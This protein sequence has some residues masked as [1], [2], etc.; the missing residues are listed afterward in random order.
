MAV[1]ARPAGRTPTVEIRSPACCGR[2]A[3]PSAWRQ[4][5]ARVQASAHS[6]EQVGAGLLAA[7]ACLGADLTVLVHARVLLAVLGTG[8]A[9]RAACLKQGA[10]E[11][12]ICTGL[13]R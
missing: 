6:C 11:V 1:G 7:A 2:C 13:A 8:L 10:I 4:R 3:R 12:D 9:R 5:S